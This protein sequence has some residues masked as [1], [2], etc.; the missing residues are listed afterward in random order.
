MTTAQISR[1]I[2]DKI[3]DELNSRK[4]REM[5]LIEQIYKKDIYYLITPRPDIYAKDIANQLGI[6]ESTISKWRKLLGMT[7][8]RRVKP[9]P[10]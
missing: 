8:V 5:R 10:K 4:T 3:K 1:T 6:D 2:R 7:N 9:G